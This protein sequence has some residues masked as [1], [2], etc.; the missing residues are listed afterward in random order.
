M[1]IM[2][3]GFSSQ[4]VPEKVLKM[5]DKSVILFSKLS[6]PAARKETLIDAMVCDWQ[7]EMKLII[8]IILN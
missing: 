2:L 8:I 5:G 1:P 3:V 4:C 7:V 6:K